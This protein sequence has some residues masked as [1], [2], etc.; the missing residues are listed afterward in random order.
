MLLLAAGN[1]G[2]V[3]CKDS[4]EESVMR[5]IQL[6]PMLLSLLLG[7]IPGNKFGTDDK[8]YCF[9]KGSVKLKLPKNWLVS[10]DEHTI[11]KIGVVSDA[12]LIDSQ[13]P[14]NGAMGCFKIDVIA[15]ERSPAA[16]L[17]GKLYDEG[18]PPVGAKIETLEI[19]HHPAARM[20]ALDEM[21]D[22]EYLWYAVAIQF[23]DGVISYASFTGL[24]DYK[25]NGI[26]D[27]VVQTMTVDS[28][29]Y[30]AALKKR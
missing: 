18:G 15:G 17:E 4:R 3:I 8:S 23:D 2:Y 30:K 14:A 9:V 22:Q 29:A 20:S 12:K 21:F 27:A 5:T 16:I 19:N 10:E 26:I 28:T 25:E 1:V 13:A 11:G 6:M 7:C 24:G